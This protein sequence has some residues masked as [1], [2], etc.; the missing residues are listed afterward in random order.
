MLAQLVADRAAHATP[1]DPVGFAVFVGL[2]VVAI[3]LGR[4]RPV[5]AI[6]MLVICAPF[7]FARDVG[8]TTITLEK[9]ALLGTLAGLGSRGEGLSAL[10]SPAARALVVSGLL[11]AFATALSIAAALDRGAALREAF[12]AFEYVVLFA[13]VVVAARCEIELPGIPFALGATVLA[14]SA[15][16][17]A[18]EW[19]GA[20]SV[21]EFG[22]QLIPRIA[23][24]LEGPNQLAG[25]LGIALCLLLAI[26]W[27]VRGFPIGR[28]ALGV[29]IV[30]EVLTIS[31]A[32]FVAAGLGIAVVATLGR[33]R[34]ETGDYLTL[35][36][37]VLAS[38]AIVAFLGIGATHLSL[39]GLALLGHFWSLGESH[40]PGAVGNRSQLWHAAIAL[41]HAHPIFGIGAGNFEKELGLVGY[42]KLHTHA[43]SLYLQALVE[44]GIP[45][46]VATI[47]L[48]VVSIVA[49]ARGPHSDPYVLGALGASVGFA[50]HQVTDLLVFYPKIGDLWW[51]VLALGAAR[52]DE[53]AG[54]PATR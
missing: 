36:G 50:L 52:S 34:F 8:Q 33:R 45:L 35:A 46:F 7:S 5:A 20:P 39:A 43:N 22:T 24:P 12:K 4:A 48:G 29:G 47:A 13:T 27:R 37:S 42:P 1:L 28:L 44:G 11:V 54:R 17:L 30:A 26:G 40:D 6:A 23:G 14:V 41:W 3:V 2:F 9:I 51:I 49:F 16:A 21:L 25:Y 19:R 31:R 38:L 15:L 18:Q 53:G 32:G 10:R